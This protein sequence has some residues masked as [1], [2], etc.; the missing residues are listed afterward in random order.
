MQ[1]F[2]N[3]VAH[4]SIEKCLSSNAFCFKYVFFIKWPCA[5]I[6]RSRNGQQKFLDRD[7]SEV[8]TT[9][10]PQA[11][12]EPLPEVKFKFPS[13]SKYSLPA[14][15][16]LRSVR[17][18]DLIITD[19]I[20]ISGELWRVG[21]LVRHKDIVSAIVLI[22]L[23]KPTNKVEFAVAKE[24]GQV[25]AWNIPLSALSVPR[26]DEAKTE[27]TLRSLVDQN[28]AVL[29][30]THLKDLAVR[31]HRAPE[32]KSPR[33]D[34][35][36][37]KRTPKKIDRFSPALPQAPRPPT[38]KQPKQIDEDMAL[39]PT[40][41]T[42]EVT[43]GTHK[44]KTGIVQSYSAKFVSLRGIDDPHELLK[45]GQN[46]ISS[47]LITPLKERSQDSLRQHATQVA[48]SESRSRSNS[49]KLRGHRSR[50]RVVERRSHHSH[51]RSASPSS[52]A[53]SSC[54]SDSSSP[55][56]FVVVKKRRHRRSHSRGDRS[57][58]RRSHSRGHT[59]CRH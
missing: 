29:V 14:D 2:S 25:S 56:E 55:E 44:G 40:G 19:R 48:H 9:V 49:P 30:D 46:H 10:V 12:D 54:S 33:S 18:D 58:S 53:E 43:G 26:L 5:Q 38:A 42:V 36:L 51:R 41:S 34:P 11:A 15:A 57:H 50:P 47:A 39:P 3:K 20:I 21:S 35:S 8:I 32:T 24:L 6:P 52:S 59:H 28:T 37:G 22:K 31:K 13:R 4:F 16:V 1:Q 17:E 45:C 27:E 23:H 7:M